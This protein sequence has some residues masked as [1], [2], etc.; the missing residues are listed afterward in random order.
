V[1]LSAVLVPA[2]KN[3]STAATAQSLVSALGGP[4]RIRRDGAL[5]ER[6]AFS[7][8]RRFAFPSPIGAVRGRLGESPD[9]W[10]LPRVWP[11]LRDVDFWIDTRRRALG[12]L[13][14]AA[15][16]HRS[17]LALVRSLQSAGRS[18]TKYLGARSGGFGIHVEAASGA[19]VTAGFVHATHSYVVAVAPAVLAA[20]AM[21]SGRFRGSGL[22]PPDR[23]VDPREL[24]AW[25][26]G[27]G[28]NAFGIE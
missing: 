6:R 21:A 25:L 23:H 5:V 7:E 22:I 13:L 8:V 28:V 19:R 1:R 26:E 11:T 16:R 24:A 3:T 17:V 15:A 10:L 20:A 9:A 18:M 14:A 4:I 2:T 27:A 12:A